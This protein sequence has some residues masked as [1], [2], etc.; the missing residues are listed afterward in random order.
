[1]SEKNGIRVFGDQ[2]NT[3]KD[4]RLKNL[5][6][7]RRTKQ[8]VSRVPIK[9]RI[10]L[11]GK[12]ENKPIPTLSRSQTSIDKLEVVTNRAKKPVI[13]TKPSLL[14]SSSSL[15]FT[16]TKQQFKPLNPIPYKVDTQVDPNAKIIQ[17]TKTVFDPSLASRLPDLEQFGV[18]TDS[19]RKNHIPLNTPPVNLTETFS[20][21]TSSL[22]ASN[23][24]QRIL[25][26]VDPVKIDRS[27]QLD[28]YINDPSR[29][30]LFEELVNDESSV[31]VAPPPITEPVHEFLLSDEDLS[32]IK[33][34]KRNHRFAVSDLD[35]HEIKLDELSGLDE[36]IQVDEVGLNEKDL[37]DLLDF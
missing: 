6:S 28:D 11:G 15:G 20:Q 14:K 30:A 25:H 34:V 23:V 31:G 10:P 37:Q 36:D 29:K 18:D 1:M 24:P 27:K 8:P 32:N 13:A 35:F 2:E 5:D 4:L 3:I 7:N 16:Y 22:N 21:D 26:D 33:K 19:L 12:D 17:N 9:G